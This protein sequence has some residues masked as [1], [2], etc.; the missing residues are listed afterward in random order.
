MSKP[1]NLLIGRTVEVTKVIFGL[2]VG[3][4]GMALLAVLSVKFAAIGAAVFVAYMT[5]ALLV[6]LWAG[7][8]DRSSSPQS[9]RRRILGAVGAGLLFLIGPLTLILGESGLGLPLMFVGLVLYANSKQDR[10]AHRVMDEPS[11]YRYDG[12]HHH[13]DDDG[14]G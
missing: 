14:D 2:V 12:H 6:D 5:W 10:A 13:D 4:L 7:L 11:G 9:R 3:L 8:F 1:M